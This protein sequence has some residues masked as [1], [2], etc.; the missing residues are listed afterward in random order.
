M[1]AL[2][3]LHGVRVGREVNVAVHRA[4]AEPIATEVAAGRGVTSAAD[5]WG[6]GATL[7]A[8]LE[9]HAPYDLNGSA[10]EIVNL[11]V[12]GEVPRTR[13]D[14]SDEIWRYDDAETLS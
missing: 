8:V 3:Q 11:V 7:Y 4:T 12:H 13:R 1:T 6:L 5:L 14:L 2:R 9:G 10:L